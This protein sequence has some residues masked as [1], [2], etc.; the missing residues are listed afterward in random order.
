MWIVRDHSE[1]IPVKVP[2]IVSRELFESV[3]EKLR[4]HEERYCQP[5]H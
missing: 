2:A 5:R 4:Q 1:W 3:Q